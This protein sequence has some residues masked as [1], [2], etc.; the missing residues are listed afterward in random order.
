[1]T[2]L[3]LAKAPAGLASAGHGTSCNIAAVSCVPKR[4]GCLATTMV[5]VDTGFLFASKFFACM[6]AWLDNQV[7]AMNTASRPKTT[8]KPIMTMVLER[9]LVLPCLTRQIRL[10]GKTS[11]QEVFNY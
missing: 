7:W 9:T 10:C 4:S 2:S 3:I 8:A 1:M 5:C 11:G 6:L